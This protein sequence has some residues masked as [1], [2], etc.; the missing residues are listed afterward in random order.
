LISFDSSSQEL[1]TDVSPECIHK[2]NVLSDNINQKLTKQWKCNTKRIKE[3]QY[4]K[5]LIEKVKCCIHYDSY[6]MG[7]NQIKQYKECDYQ[8]FKRIEDPKLEMKK[9]ESG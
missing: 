8:Q 9:K 7:L 6:D 3:C 4:P 2:L 5:E 1:S